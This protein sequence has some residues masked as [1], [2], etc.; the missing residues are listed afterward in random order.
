MH[1]PAGNTFG[2]GAPYAPVGATSNPIREWGD[3]L[4]VLGSVI[5][6]IASA[7]VTGQAILANYSPRNYPFLSV[8]PTALG[9]AGFLLVAGGCLRFL[10]TPRRHPKEPF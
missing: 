7:L 6:V 2:G 3:G 10:G 9:A 1:T 4:L 8:W 5:L